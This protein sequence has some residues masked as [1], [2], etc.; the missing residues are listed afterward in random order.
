VT[1]TP[2][3]QLIPADANGAA[4][5]DDTVSVTTSVRDGADVRLFLGALATLIGDTLSRHQDTVTRIA[6]I[7]TTKGDGAQRD[8]IITLQNF[9]RLQQEFAQLG[10]ALESY[11]SVVAFSKSDVSRVRQGLGVVEAINMADLKIRLLQLL[12]IDGIDVALPPEEEIF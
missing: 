6:D 1:V 3:K 8:L 7:V 5:I 10:E 4:D 9:D 12:K 2:I 11:A